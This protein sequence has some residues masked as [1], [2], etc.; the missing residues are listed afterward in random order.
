MATV[1][2]ARLTLRVGRR[3][4]L[5]W[6]LGIAAMTT[7]YAASFS[8]IGRAKSAAIN[9][10]PESLRKALD[11]QDLS[12][13][14]GYLASTVFGI[15]LIL[16][17]TIYAINSATR[18][19][20]GDEDAGTLDLVLAY[21]VSR[22]GL[23]LTRSACS[24]AVMGVLGAVVLAVLCAV[25]GPAGLHI[26]VGP[27]A[28]TTLTWVLLG[29]AIGGVAMLVSAVSGRRS[30]TLAVSAAIALFA[31]LADS[32]LPLIAHLGWLRD[33][34]PYGWFTSGTPLRNGLQPGQCAL[35]L[36]TAVVATALAAIAFERR[37]VHV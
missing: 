5:G 15:P 3:G 31:Y 21:P 13:A 34:S 32:F 30:M 22:I 2:L 17:V 24:A 26:G 6:I 11:L 16:L 37:D 12:T 4:T 7:L 18:S 23:V 29:W 36:G 14:P 28:A 1:D 25:R 35:L 8:S 19:I 20:A 10:Y 27:L 9:G 33:V